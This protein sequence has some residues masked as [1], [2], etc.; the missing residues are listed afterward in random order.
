MLFLLYQNMSNTYQVVATSKWNMAL[1]ASV[2]KP[3]DTL[4]FVY[5]GYKQ[6]EAPFNH[7][8]WPIYIKA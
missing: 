3:E 2:D 6:G 5:V 1:E 4:K 8:N 7:S